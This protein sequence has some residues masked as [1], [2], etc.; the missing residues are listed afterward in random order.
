MGIFQFLNYLLQDATRQSLTPRLRESLYGLAVLHDSEA[1]A[2]LKAMLKSPLLRRL[3][4]KYIGRLATAYLPPSANISTRHVK[5]LFGQT[6]QT[7][8]QV[9]QSDLDF[10]VPEEVD[11][12]LGG[13]L[14][15]LSDTVCHSPAR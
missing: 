8:A 6:D 15:S 4:I 1:N 2:N 10:E 7:A 3:R 11:A 12:L 13:L 14:A 9:S 5:G